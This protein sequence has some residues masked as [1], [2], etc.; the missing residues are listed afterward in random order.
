MSHSKL[1][2][3]VKL[4]NHNFPLNKLEAWLSAKGANER[5]VVLY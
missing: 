4:P 2:V 3:Q 5:T 1:N